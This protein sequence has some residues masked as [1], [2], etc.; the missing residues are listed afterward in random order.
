M[1][2]TVLVVDDDPTQRRLIQ[3]VLE[4]EGVWIG[5]GLACAI[6]AVVIVW[7]VMLALLWSALFVLGNLFGITLPFG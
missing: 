5:I 7:G 6:L 2:K 3:G 4:R 1:T